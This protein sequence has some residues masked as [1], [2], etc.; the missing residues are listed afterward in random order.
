MTK[1]IYEKQSIKTKIMRQ[2]SK[3]QDKDKPSRQKSKRQDKDKAKLWT[4]WDIEPYPSP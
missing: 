4:S 2:K 3:R 1:V